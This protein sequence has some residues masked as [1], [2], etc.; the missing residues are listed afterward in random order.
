[1]EEYGSKRTQHHIKNM[2]RAKRLR[3]LL[4]TIFGALISAGLIAAVILWAYHSD[5]F[6]PQ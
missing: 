2:Q 3:A 6:K 5:R 4:L 1:M